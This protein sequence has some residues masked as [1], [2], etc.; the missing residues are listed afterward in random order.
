SN[1]K[2]VHHFGSRSEQR[3]A[4]LWLKLCEIK[5]H[6]GLKKQKPILL[7]DDVFSEFDAKNKKIILELVQ[8]YQSILTTT[9][10]EITELKGFTKTIIKL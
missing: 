3:F 6:E 8:D 1:G 4:I 9:E 2:S 5:Y 7:L 10:K